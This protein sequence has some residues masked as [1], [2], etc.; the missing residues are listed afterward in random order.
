MHLR[1]EILLAPR[2]APLLALTTRDVRLRSLLFLSLALF[3][4]FI[5]KRSP[6]CG[7]ISNLIPSLHRRTTLNSSSVVGTMAEPQPS[8]NRNAGATAYGGV[9]AQEPVN[10]TN[11]TAGNDSNQDVRPEKKVTLCGVC[12]QVPSKYKCPRCYLP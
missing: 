1:P 8:D 2:V 12:E 9:S 10:E 5:A 11:E 6:L 3:V 4:C 7:P